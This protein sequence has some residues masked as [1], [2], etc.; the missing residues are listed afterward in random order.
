MSNDVLRRLAATI[1]DRRTARPEDSHT[2]R[3]LD[4]APIRPAKKLGEE[5]VEVAIA[6]LAQDKSALIGESADL[7]YH[8]LVV[9]ESRHISLDD[10]YQELE[11][12]M[13]ATELQKRRKAAAS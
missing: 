7:L 10:V 8:L 4:G 6:A 13:S 12:R 11:R 5:A 9:L 3:L 2:R 1:K